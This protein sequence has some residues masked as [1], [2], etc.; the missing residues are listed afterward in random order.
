[1]SQQRFAV[2][3]EL[4]ADGA[5]PAAWRAAGHAP[6]TLLS[7][8]RVAALVQAAE[9]FGFT[10]ASF[11][12][13]PVPPEHGPDVTARVD[14]VQRAAFAAA[15]TSAIGLLPSAHVVYSEPFHVATQLASLDWASHGRA[16]WIVTG[17]ADARAAAALGRDLIDDAAAERERDDVIEVARRLWDSWEDDAVIRDAAT[18]R[19]LDRDKLHYVDFEGPGFSVKGPSITPRPPQGQPLVVAPAGAA[20]VDVALVDGADAAQL[21]RAADRAR[22]G[23]AP[24]VWAELEVVLDARGVR[25]R[26]RLADLDVFTGWQPTTRLRHVGTADELAEL[27]GELSRFADGVRL[28]PA[29]LDLD[30]EELGR[31]VLPRLRRAI[32]FSSPRP[33]DTLRTSLG[34]GHPVN[35]YSREAVSP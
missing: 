14:A 5:H 25:A 3:I 22:A 20:G 9:R 12:D 26:Q 24:L 17:G 34:L 1:M 8:R 11:D 10:A 15:G 29:V 28:H 33:G 18:G 4:D 23:G 21:E 27:V 31:A 19:Y 16:G 30:L 7:P 35:R 32:G 13:A 2:A 6:R